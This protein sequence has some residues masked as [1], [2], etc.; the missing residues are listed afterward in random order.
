MQQ[1]WEF[2]KIVGSDGN[3][4]PRSPLEEYVGGKRIR[5]SSKRNI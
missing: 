1:N 2:L 4:V 5:G 3:A